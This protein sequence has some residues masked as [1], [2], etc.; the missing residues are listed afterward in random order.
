MSRPIQRTDSTGVAIVFGAAAALGTLGVI[1]SAAF[2]AGMSAASFTALRAIL[3]ATILGAIVLRGLQPSANL[4]ALPQPEKR[5][6]L[7]AIAANGSMNLLLFTGFQVMTVG[8]VMTIF[9]TYPM[10]VM[11]VQTA[12][13]REQV[14]PLRVAAVLIAMA[15]LVLVIGSEVGPAAFVSF[16]GIG[17]G[18]A[19][20]TCQTG[21]LVISRDGYPTVPA[22]QATSLTL[23]G[24]ALISGTAALM[25]GNVGSFNAWASE[26][27]AWVAVFIAG[28]LG[29]AIPKVLLLVGVRRIGGTRTA[30]V[31]LSE[32][33]VAVT[34]AAI[35]LGEP[36]V[37][38]QLVGGA[39]I[40]LGAAL[41]QRPTMADNAGAS[42]AQVESAWTS[43]E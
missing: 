38:A 8:L 28:T 22:V 39:A 14:T 10:M 17:L 2:E 34:F 31:M 40:L 4:R 33:V 9:Y 35:A 12:R 18:L 13:G 27:A 1:S 30:T 41:V 11:I 19:A 24:G 21:F 5:L 26:P 25:V 20:A 36:I 3:G 23:I 42:S 37:A 43:R 7:L 32:P 16:A 6:L 15:G 29:A